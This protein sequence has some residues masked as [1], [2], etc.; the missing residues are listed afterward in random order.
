MFGRSN[1]A[2]TLFLVSLCSYL[3]NRPKTAASLDR[4][5]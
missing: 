2:L 5:V 1:P 3:A 4:Y